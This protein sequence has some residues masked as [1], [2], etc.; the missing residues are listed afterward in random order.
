MVQK[1]NKEQDAEEE[2]K[3]NYAWLIPRAAIMGPVRGA[4]QGASVYK[5]LFVT[6]GILLSMVI[7]FAKWIILSTIAVY[8]IVETIKYIRNEIAEQKKLWLQKK[9]LSK[10]KEEGIGHEIEKEALLPEKKSTWAS[11]SEKIFD[12]VEVAIR[13]F[14]DSGKLVLSAFFLLGLNYK[15]HLFIAHP[16]ILYATIGFATVFGIM[17]F[18]ELHSLNKRKKE[19]QTLHTEKKQYTSQLREELS[20]NENL[21]IDEKSS[22]VYVQVKYEKK[23]GKPNAFQKPNKLP[24]SELHKGRMFVHVFTGIVNGA[25]LC[26]TMFFLSGVF[27]PALGI[28]PLLML[29]GSITAGGL[30]AVRFGA[31]ERRRQQQEF[32]AKEKLEYYK[33]RYKSICNTLIEEYTPTQIEEITSNLSTNPQYN[34]EPKHTPKLAKADHLIQGICSRVRHVG[35]GFKNSSKLIMAAL[36][37]AGIGFATHGLAT[38]IPISIAVA[39]YCGLTFLEFNTKSNSIKRVADLKTETKALKA[40]MIEL[41]RAMLISD[42]QMPQAVENPL[43]VT[44][45]EHNQV[46]TKKWQKAMRT[47][48]ED[49]S[50]FIASHRKSTNSKPELKPRPLTLIY[51]ERNSIKINLQKT[52][53]FPAAKIKKLILPSASCSQQARG[54]RSLTPVTSPIA[55]V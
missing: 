2:F 25:Y 29:G 42:Q 48:F 40:K 35:R 28:N 32:A 50:F 16:I 34:P 51:P 36:L 19:I 27:F 54:Y 23:Y 22:P 10:R 11:L 12:Y 38:I 21:Q 20:K 44:A 41:Q 7:P 9:A 47:S 13:S 33:Q 3:I 18:V 53:F 46:E 55:T 8:S 43:P 26:V 45:E 30:F 17:G 6:L 4:Y 52:S 14:K 39:T 49:P 15:A 5:L 24:S 31:E 37:I 1:S